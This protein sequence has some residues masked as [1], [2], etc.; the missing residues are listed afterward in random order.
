MGEGGVVRLFFLGWVWRASK[1][2]QFFANRVE[3]E[4]KRD[5]ICLRFWR[6][7]ERGGGKVRKNRAHTSASA[8]GVALAM[9]NS[10]P[11]A[12]LRG[13]SVSFMPLLY[14]RMGW[15]SAYGGEW[16]SSV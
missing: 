2:H 15:R 1:P 5:G 3:S 8:C 6:E 7:R 10:P 13:F 11:H 16:S 4:G 14:L 12:A 9:E